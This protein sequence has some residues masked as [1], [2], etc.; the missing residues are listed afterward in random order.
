VPH[1]FVVMKPWTVLLACLCLAGIVRAADSDRF[2]QWLKT[3]ESKEA[4]LEKL[5]SDQV[6]VLDALVRKDISNRG[7]GRPEG[8]P[9]EFS[10]RLTPDQLRNTGLIGLTPAEVARVD[11][12]VG[13]FAGAKLARTLLAP[14]VYIARTMRPV[15]PR[16]KKK[17]REIHG[18]FSLSM[19]WGSDGYSE[20]SGSMVL[21]MD[22]PERNLSI[23]V[24][25]SETHVKGPAGAIYRDGYYPPYYP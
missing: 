12:F 14:P 15:E 2:S 4:G 19:G 6:A 18:S 1:A 9:D 13:R 16:E 21:R 25:Y 3:E 17:E 5:S 24:G 10:K 20:R 11:A 7:A 22:D 8:S 23:S